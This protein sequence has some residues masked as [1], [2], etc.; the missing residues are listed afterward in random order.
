MLTLQQIAENSLE[1]EYNCWIWQ[2]VLFAQGYARYRDLRVHR[3][4]YELYNSTKIPEGFYVCHTCDI[5][6]C[7]N[8]EHL[9]LGTPKENSKDRDSKLRHYHGESVN[10]N[11]LT[12]QQ[13]IEI[14]NLYAKIK[15]KYGALSM[16]GNLYGISHTQVRYIVDGTSWKHLHLEPIF[17]KYN[18]S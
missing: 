18:K 17:V 1:D 7:V 5:P 6:C 2:G 3:L 15:T 12:E 11:K 16:V 13:V 14:Y 10:T 9:F 4:S 8:P